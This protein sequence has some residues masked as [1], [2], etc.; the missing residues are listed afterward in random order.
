MRSPGLLNVPVSLPDLSSAR[1]TATVTSCDGAWIDPSQW[2]DG[3]T[4]ASPACPRD[5]GASATKTANDKINPSR[6]LQHSERSEQ[7]LRFERI[8]GISFFVVVD[9]KSRRASRA[10]AA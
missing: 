2:P 6:R 3:S 5:G 10:A 4:A 7:V 9:Q 1:S 8:I